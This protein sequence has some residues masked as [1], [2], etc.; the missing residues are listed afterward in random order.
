LRVKNKELNES[1]QRYLENVHTDNQGIEETYTKKINELN[2]EHQQ[3]IAAMAE[4]YD[5]KI[6]GIN[7]DN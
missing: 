7:R 1:Y 3:M 2:R 6:N 5:N 4:E